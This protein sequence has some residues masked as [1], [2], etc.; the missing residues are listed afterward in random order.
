MKIWK[1]EKNKQRFDLINYTKK[2]LAEHANSDVRI[3]VG[4]DSQNLKRKPATGYITCVAFHVGQM[5]KTTGLF[6]GHGVH[7]LYTEK[8]LKKIHDTFLRLWKEVE[9]TMETAEHLRNAGILVHQVDLDFNQ[10]E[11]H[12]SNRC[13]TAGTGLLTGLGYRVAS[14]PDDLFATCAADDLIHRINWKTIKFIN[15]YITVLITKKKQIMKNIKTFRQFLNENINEST[16]PAEISDYTGELSQ[17][18]LEDYSDDAMAKLKAAQKK[19]SYIIVD[20]GG[21]PMS[22]DDIEILLKKKGIKYEIFDDQ[23]NSLNIIVF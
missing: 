10:D 2:T 5:D 17:I 16:V 21:M 3:Y 6:M 19:Y 4:T 7:I 20:D 8:K 23:D 13:N 22:F 18:A 15:R 14:K 1:T 12:A 9:L 11:I